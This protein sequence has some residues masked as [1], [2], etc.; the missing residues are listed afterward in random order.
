[1][2]IGHKPLRIL[3]KEDFPHPL[4]PV[5]MTFSPWWIYKLISRTSFS[6]L[7]VTIGTRSKIIVS[8]ISWS[9]KQIEEDYEK[10][11]FIRLS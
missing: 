10:Y 11:I 2:K 6:P 9:C 8:S 1:M 4:G 5:T 3:N 7:G